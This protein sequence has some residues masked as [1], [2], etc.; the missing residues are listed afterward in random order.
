MTDHVPPPT[1]QVAQTIARGGNP[2]WE[3]TFEHP[4]HGPLTFRGQLPTNGQTLAHRVAL[5]A[6]LAELPDV[7]TARNPTLI[8]AA[9]LAAMEL[10][11]GA[12]GAAR[13]LM[14]PEISRTE[15]ETERGTI[16]RKVFYNADEDTDADFVV[17]VWMAYSAWRASLLEELDA[18]KGP[19]GEITGSG[20]STSSTAPTVSPSTTPA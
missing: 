9:G 16:V 6:R 2:P 14:L 17:D 10:V 13:L 19:S 18:V 20:S 5:D 1:S 15:E 4:R 12:S 7:A 3:Q 8:L 11:D